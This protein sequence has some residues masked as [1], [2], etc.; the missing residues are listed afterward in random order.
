MIVSKF[1]S[2]D[3][4]RVLNTEIG[5]QILTFSE[6]SR[7]TNDI[8]VIC[9]FNDLICPYTW[10]RLYLFA[11]IADATKEPCHGGPTLA[12]IR[13]RPLVALVTRE[14]VTGVGGRLDSQRLTLAQRDR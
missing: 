12:L 2:H 3:T 5:I 6:F 8:S 7:I 9:V 14:V 13:V 11:G 10:R 1:V 4:D